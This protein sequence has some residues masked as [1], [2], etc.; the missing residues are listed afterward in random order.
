MDLQV[1]SHGVAEGW[2]HIVNF[3]GCHVVYGA[4]EVT[5]VCIGSHRQVGEP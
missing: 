1:P 2:T 3:Q 5:G 4:L